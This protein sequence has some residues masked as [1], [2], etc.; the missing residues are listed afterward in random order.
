[1]SRYYSIVIL[2]FLSACNDDVVS[3]ATDGD[4]PTCGNGDLEGGDACTSICQ[5][6]STPL[7]CVTLL[8]GVGV[9]DER[10]AGLLLLADGS[11][12]AGGAYSPTDDG[13]RA[14]LG[15]FDA[16]GEALWLEE[17]A[18]DD[19]TTSELLALD[20]LGTD[21]SAGAWALLR[22]GET[23]QVLQFDTQGTVA[24]RLDLEALSDDPEGP[25]DALDMVATPGALW[26]AGTRASDLWLGRLALDGQ[27]LT[28]VLI[29]DGAGFHDEAR[30]LARSEAG[31]AL[32]ATI[33]T[34]PEFIEDVGVLPPSRVLVIAFDLGGHEL[35]RSTL[36]ADEQGVARHAEAIISD[37]AEGWIVGGTQYE[38]GAL[39]WTHDA[40]MAHVHPAQGWEWESAGPD[41]VSGVASLRNLASLHQG[42]VLSVGYAVIDGQSHAWLTCSD[43]DSGET[44]WQ[45]ERSPPEGYDY[46]QSDV[47]AWDGDTQLRTSG[48]VKTHFE[49]SAVQSCLFSAE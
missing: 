10:A 37:G 2:L 6:S 41:T 18:L 4:E 36:G 42:S 9:G 22:E 47:A 24:A 15:R 26:L 12:I 5:L 16:S 48:L 25:G 28:T 43:L 21:A 20:T 19:D 3:V 46:A 39:P 27:V 49:R 13:L 8:E 34:G 17:P 7:G 33:A 11:F 14:W 44:R 30:T 40:W 1:M 35:A 38:A 32:A 31:V 45:S 23:Q 29:E